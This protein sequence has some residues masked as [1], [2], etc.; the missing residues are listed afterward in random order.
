MT[1]PYPIFRHFISSVWQ[2]QRQRLIKV[3]ELIHLEWMDP[4]DGIIA[5]LKR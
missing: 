2:K 1:Q 5:E 4:G 3:E